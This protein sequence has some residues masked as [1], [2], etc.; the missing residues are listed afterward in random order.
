M[1]LL[2][3]S[4]ALFLIVS[5]FPTFAFSQNK[6]K[7]K[8]KKAETKPLEVKTN[9]LVIN[10]Q[11]G[12]IDDVKQEE[13]KL[14]EDGVEQKIIYFAKKEPTLNIAL[15]MDNTGSMRLLLEEVIYVGK[16]IVDNLRET[17][18]AF[19]VRF[20]SNEAVE[21]IEEWTSDKTKLNLA[22][23]S[24]FVQGGLSAVLDAVY[25]SAQE[26]LKKESKN[27]NKRYAIFLVSDAEDRGSYYKYNDVI[28][29][30]KGTDIQVFVLSYAQGAP[31]KKKKAQKLSQLLSLDT[32]GTTYSL[33]EKYKVEELNEILKKMIIELRSN[34][35][36]GYTST[37]PK[38]D[39]ATRKLTVEIAQGAKGE[40]RRV[41]TRESFTVPED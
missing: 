30:F 15:V 6:S 33:A 23:E 31:L 28:K 27:K 8:D 12:Y 20:V 36:V 14:F 2:K 17:D 16:T 18:E 29:L 41:I 25:L 10:E 4:I 1:K 32:G 5:L 7:D 39:G 3:F 35:V 13:I 9:L 19:V 34:Y 37:N 38:R 40:K 24:M 22:L 21:V 11:N 26:L